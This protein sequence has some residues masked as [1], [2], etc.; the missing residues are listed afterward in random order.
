MGWGKPKPALKQPE[1]F[2]FCRKAAVDIVP[3]KSMTEREFRRLEDDSV[4]ESSEVHVA[5]AATSAVSAPASSAA[6]EGQRHTTATARLVPY[7]MSSDE[8]DKDEN[9]EADKASKRSTS[10]LLPFLF[11]WPLSVA[12]I[13]CAFLGNTFSFARRAVH[14]MD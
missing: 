5:A 6:S 12:V 10:T 13:L 1:L 11:F 3:A 7:P 14:P 4:T 8:E 2:A 9:Y